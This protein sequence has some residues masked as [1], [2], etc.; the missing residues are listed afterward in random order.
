MAEP[1]FADNKSSQRFERGW[2]VLQLIIEISVGLIVLAGLAGLL[3]TGPLSSHVELFRTIPLQVSYQRIMRRTVASEIKMRAMAPLSSQTLEIELPNKLTDAVDVTS[4]SPRSVAMRAEADGIVYV[5]Q[6]G[7]EK[8]GTI[9]FS[10]KPRSP[11]WI[12]STLRAN[13]QVLPLHTLVLP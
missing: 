2:N 5:F 4:T 10:V 7:Q 6:L 11:G 12:D 3:G 1:L 13:G 8:L 9:I